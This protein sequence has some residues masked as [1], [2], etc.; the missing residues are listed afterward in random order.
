MTP[1]VVAWPS[2]MSPVSRASDREVTVTARPSLPVRRL[3]MSA[4]PLAVSAISALSTEA[5]SA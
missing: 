2:T 4:S 3:P 1:R 5:S